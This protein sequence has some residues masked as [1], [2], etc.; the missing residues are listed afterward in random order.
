M[1]TYLDTSVLVSA[2]TIEAETPLA[3]AWLRRGRE[4]AVSDW[5]FTEVASAL[6]LK[7]RTG[8]ISSSDRV[9]AASAFGKLSASFTLIPVER[10]H[11]RTA[12]D[13]IGLVGVPLRAS[14][15]LHL[16]VCAAR[17]LPLATLDRGMAE[18]AVIIGVEV[19]D[20]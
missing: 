14:D 8:A 12:A 3:V 20:L 5:S 15:A 19:V 9:R 17:R 7:V 11:F 10:D 1:A 2:L 13:Y 4:V 6:S 18:A 16:A